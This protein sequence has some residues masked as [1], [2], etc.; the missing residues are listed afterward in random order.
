M[1]MTI[2]SDWRSAQR[3]GYTRPKTD[4]SL[5]LGWR[6]LDR[7]GAPRQRW[8]RPGRLRARTAENG[9]RARRFAK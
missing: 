7:A 3:A 2:P 6:R 5:L 4:E 9:R 8:W 1:G